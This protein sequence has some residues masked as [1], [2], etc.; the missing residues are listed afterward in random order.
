M[1]DAAQFTANLQTAMARFIYVDANPYDTAARLIAEGDRTLITASRLAARALNAPHQSLTYGATKTLEQAGWT[2]AS[3]LKAQAIFRQVLQDI[4]QPA[5]LLGTA[6]AWLPTVRSLLQ[7]SPNLGT[8]SGTFS[9][10]TYQLLQV[11]QAFQQTLH[12]ER[13]VDL[14]ELYWRA[15]EQT[16]AS[17]SVLIYGYFQ[18]RL[19]E[20]AWMNAIAA[21]D[22]VLFLPA[23]DAPLFQDVQQSVKWLVEQGWEVVVEASEEGEIRA[24]LSQAFIGKQGT[25]PSPGNRPLGPPLQHL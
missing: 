14:S 23:P 3:T 9:E 5:D 17:Q 4:L 19:D 21:P 2:I 10:R 25:V 12:K 18:P 15:I 8:V 7:S 1:P 11:A 24:H 6:N 13:L 22:S 16:P 20:L